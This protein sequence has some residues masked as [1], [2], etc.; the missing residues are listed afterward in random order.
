MM[1]RFIFHILTCLQFARYNTVAQTPQA[2]P[3]FNLLVKSTLIADGA[4]LKLISRQFSFTEGPA[5]D[6]NGNVFFTDQPNNTIW[7]Y[8]TDGKIT[9][10]LNKAG[11]SNGMYFDADGNLITCA[12]EDNQ[13]WSIDPQGKINVL[14]KDLN[15]LHFNGPNDLWIAPNGDIYFT[16]PYYQRAYWKRTTPEIPAQNVYIFRKGRPPLAV[17]DNLMQPNGIIGSPDGQYLYVADIK[18][19]KTYRYKIAT[20]GTLTEQTLFAPK[21]SD[22]MTMDEQGNIYLTGDGVWIYNSIGELIEHLKVPEGWTANVTFGGKDRNE[23]FVS[24][25]KGVYVVKMKVRGAK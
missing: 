5:V 19:D 16:D 10:F 18:A 8:S 6:K 3:A 14:L 15:G 12:D 20:N 25:S 22:G 17:A 1:Y 13:L 2:P 24:A 21:G 4:E 7:K 23:L 9:L 11:R